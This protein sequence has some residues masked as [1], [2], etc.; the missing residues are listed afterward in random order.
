MKKESDR[1]FRAGLEWERR[2]SKEKELGL[3]LWPYILNNV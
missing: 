2:L 1:V 3:S